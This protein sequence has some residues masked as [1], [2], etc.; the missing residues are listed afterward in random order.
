VF[1]T[2]FGILPHKAYRSVFSLWVFFEYSLAFMFASL[3]LDPPI[4]AF[5]IAGMINLCNHIWL[6]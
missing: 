6:L 3:S 5:S 2:E 4:Y 1:A